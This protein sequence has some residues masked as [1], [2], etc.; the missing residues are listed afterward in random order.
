METKEY[1][2]FRV[3]CETKRVKRVDNMKIGERTKQLIKCRALLSDVFE[4]VTNIV[5]E[6]CSNDDNLKEELLQPFYDAH[7]ECDN[8]LMK[9]ISMFVENTMLCKDYRSI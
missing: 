3:P 9:L 2:G 6:E 4:F 8:E 7:T 1:A 5:M